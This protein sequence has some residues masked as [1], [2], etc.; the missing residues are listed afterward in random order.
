MQT[1]VYALST[2]PAIAWLLTLLLK[3]FGILTTTALLVFALRRYFSSAAAHLCWLCGLLAAAAVPVLDLL[4]SSL[5]GDVVSANSLSL[6]T[7]TPTVEAAVNAASTI[8]VASV[9]LYLYV[10]VVAVGIIALAF[11]YWRLHRLDSS[12]E[13]IDNNTLADRCQELA[14]LL[15][16]RRPVTIKCSA[17]IESPVSYGLRNPVVLLPAGCEYWNE[18]VSDQVLTHELAHIARADWLSLLFS[19]LLCVLLWANPLVWISSKQLHDESEQ[20]CDSIVAT[21]NN[22]RIHYAE[23]LL[24][25]AKQRKQL[26]TTRWQTALAQPMYGKH[27][28][29]VR[30]HNILEGKLVAKTSRTLKAIAAFTVLFASLS[31]SSLQLVAADSGLADR[32]YLPIRADSPLYPSRAAEA[33]IEGW[34]LLSFTVR[35][36]GTVDANSVEILDA[37]PP[38]YFE[39][40]SRNAALRFEFEPRI[41]D[42]LAVDV[43]GVEY[44][45]RYHLSEGAAN[46]NRPPPEA[47]R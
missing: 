20:A 38:G 31:L 18:S 42:G 32:D 9:F 12:A 15:D 45:F 2:D 19:K 46:F 25:L 16:I 10:A 41:V 5:P 11:A 28:L 4:R 34:L 30:I 7:V 24:M 35:P 14:E 17:E 13:L 27:S 22:N 1:F 29:S 39:V 36:D 40:S 47:N 23:N 37:E 8:A 6:M 43:P 26:S 3:S 33:G 44:L 21:T